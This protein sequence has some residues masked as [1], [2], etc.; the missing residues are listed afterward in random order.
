MAAGQTGG[1]GGFFGNLGN[2]LKDPYFIQLL[3]SAGA[4]LLQGS[5]GKNTLATMQHNQSVQAYREMIARMMRGDYSDGG[6]MTQDAKGMKIDLPAPQQPATQSS[7][8]PST[9]GGVD[10]G[11]SGVQP[12]QPVQNNLWGDQT[13]GMPTNIYNMLARFFGSSQPN[14]PDLSAADVVGLSPQDIASALQLR[15]GQESLQ[16]QKMADLASLMYN[17]GVQGPYMKALTEE[18]AA[19]TQLMPKQHELDIE[20]TATDRMNAIREMYKAMEGEPLDR[21]FPI[22]SSE[23]QKLTLREWNALPATEQEYAIYAHRT[24]MRGEAP[25]SKR[26]FDMMKPT[27]RERLLRAAMD[28]PELMR[29][30]KDVGQSEATRIS[31]GEKLDEIKAKTELEGQLAGQVFFSK[32][33]WPSLIEKE[34]SNDEALKDQVWMNRADPAMA[35]QLII[36]AT[37]KRIKEKI[38]AGRG[39]IVGAPVIDQA[40]R[41]ITWTVKWPS[42]KVEPITYVAK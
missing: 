11:I 41:T 13:G 24:Q 37:V 38:T 33:E 17:V 22:P 35:S 29:V 36:N 42:G 10:Y 16:R 20:K 9:G 4:D 2:L 12:S 8:G 40:K 18:S 39:E 23:G 25:V 15:M 7:G 19:R 6:K 30:L 27:E 5:G 28:D 31:L 3:G 21:E 14:Y 34:I 32:V 1:G 26:Q